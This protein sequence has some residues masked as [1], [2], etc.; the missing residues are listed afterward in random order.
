MKSG[1]ASKRYVLSLFLRYR[2]RIYSMFYDIAI[3]EIF[4]A[5]T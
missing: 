5:G 4:A 3:Y 1:K 2:K